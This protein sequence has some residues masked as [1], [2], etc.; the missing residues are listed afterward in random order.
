M[1]ARRSIFVVDKKGVV[2]Y[3]WIADNAEIEPD[4]NK[5]EQALQE[6]ELPN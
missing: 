6:I 2:R 4:Y 3:V 1:V 5:I